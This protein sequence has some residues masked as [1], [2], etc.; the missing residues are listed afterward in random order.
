MTAFN[1]NVFGTKAASVVNGVVT[2]TDRVQITGDFESSLFYVMAG[3]HVTTITADKMTAAVT[4][5]GKLTDKIIV[6]VDATE[7][8]PAVAGTLSAYHKYAVQFRGSPVEN[9]VMSGM[10]LKAQVERLRT[11]YTLMA[12]AKPVGNQIPGDYGATK[13]ETKAKASDADA[14]A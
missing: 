11:I 6:P 8:E 1:A 4:A 2:F 10:E 12:M 3:L 7:T 5:V 13:A 14:W 9:I